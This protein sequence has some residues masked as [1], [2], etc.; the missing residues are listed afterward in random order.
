MKLIAVDGCT[1]QFSGITPMTLSNT[2]I[3]PPSA[4][5]K[6]VGKF[7]YRGNITVNAVFATTG[8]PPTLPLSFTINGSAAKCKSDGQQA[9]LEGDTSADVPW[10]Y[11]VGQTTVS[12]S[13]SCKIQAAGQQKVSGN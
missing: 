4:K 13:A 8:T 11:A 3:S 10:S 12:G 1:L 6:A 7:V 9:V 2:T 5:V